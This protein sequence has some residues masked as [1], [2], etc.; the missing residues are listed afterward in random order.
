M[1][2]YLDAP[3]A[4]AATI[5]DDGWLRTGDLGYIDDRGFIFITGRSKNIIVTGGGK[6]IYPEEIE[7]KF[8]GSD[9]I[10]EAL[11]VGRKV[12]GVGEQV[13]VV[14]VPRWDRVDAERGAV[15]REEFAAER[16]RDEVRRVNKNLASFMKIVDFI[17]RND[18]FEKTSSR[19]I[20]RF[21]YVGY[22]DPVQGGSGESRR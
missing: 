15:S 2:G 8:E 19:K 13:L 11:V 22:G 3:E 12:P 17:V 4:T 21:L 7:L 5:T 16:V 20:R 14:C 9:W 6:N 10:E 18:E 1:L